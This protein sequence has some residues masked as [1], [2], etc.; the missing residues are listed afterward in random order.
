MEKYQY[1]E[2]FIKQLKSLKLSLEK[3]PV[4]Q[5]IAETWGTKF[6]LPLLEIK[7]NHIRRVQLLWQFEYKIVISKVQAVII[8]KQVVI[9]LIIEKLRRCQYNYLE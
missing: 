4:L 1:E 9:F 5:Q 6:S 2:L 7:I 3:L 8:K